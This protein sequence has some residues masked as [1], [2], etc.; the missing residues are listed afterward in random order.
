MP[1]WKILSVEVRFEYRD[2][3]TLKAQKYGMF[4]FSDLRKK[5]FKNEFSIDYSCTGAKFSIEILVVETHACSYG[6]RWVRM[7]R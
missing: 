5:D 4:G 1:Y 2:E 6:Q 3:W 7:S